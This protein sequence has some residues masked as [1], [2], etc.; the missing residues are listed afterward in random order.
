MSQRVLVVEDDPSVRSLLDTLLSGEGYEVWTASDGT[1][2]M[3]L[4]AER[5]PAVILLDV[6]LPV[7]GGMRV[8]EQLRADGD[9]SHVPVVVVTGTVEI[10]PRLR[11]E[12]GDDRVFVK[13]FVVAD[14]LDRVAHLTGGPTNGP[15]SSAP[16]SSKDS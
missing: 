12:L 8:L 5:P 7:L 3:A 6:M 16:D 10:V 15:M 4:A 9:L 2:A 14:L 1:A 11:A 13:P